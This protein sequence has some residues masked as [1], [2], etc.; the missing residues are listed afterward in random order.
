MFDTGR[1]VSTAE[2]AAWV[3]SQRQVFQAVA[4]YM[5]PYSTTYAPDPQRRAG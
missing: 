3:K 1:V 4:R 5:P 2:F